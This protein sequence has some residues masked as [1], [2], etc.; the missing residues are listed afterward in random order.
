MLAQRLTL[1]VVILILA[2]CE[3]EERRA[4]DYA[5]DRAEAA[6]AAQVEVYESFEEELV[7]EL[8]AE[9]GAAVDDGCP[10]VEALPE[11]RDLQEMVNALPF[12]DRRPLSQW[13]R[14]TER[15]RPVQEAQLQARQDVFVRNLP[16]AYCRCVQGSVVNV[17]R[18]IADLVDPAQFDDARVNVAELPDEQLSRER[19]LF[20][21]VPGFTAP[22][23]FS[24]ERAR[25]EALEAVNQWK[26]TRRGPNDGPRGWQD[27]DPQM[28]G[29]GSREEADSAWILRGGGFA[30]RLSRDC[31]DFARYRD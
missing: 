13:K 11:A 22:A 24:P 18:A 23:G 21:G 9:W 28:V 16:G 25:A 15:L 2:A 20:F 17:R 19:L 10:E 3:S 29:V 14:Q 1:V 26:V 30:T 4:V 8:G 7:S 12:E 5:I 27:P 31:T 6:A